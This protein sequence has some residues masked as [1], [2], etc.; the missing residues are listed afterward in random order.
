MKDGVLALFNSFLIYL[1][2]CGIN[3]VAFPTSQG[4]E[5]FAASEGQSQTS[6]AP[7]LPPAP[8]PP[9]VFPGP[10]NPLPSV[11]PP[12]IAKGLPSA[13]PLGSHTGGGASS[14]LSGAPGCRGRGHGAP[15]PVLVT[16]KPPL[17]FRWFN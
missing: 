5:A 15:P 2:D 13:P 1:T 12:P 9:P 3:V 17:V 8:I 10:A 16:P 11:L 7:I 14:S 4:T 6:A